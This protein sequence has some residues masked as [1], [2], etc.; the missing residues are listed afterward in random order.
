MK[1]TISRQLGL[2]ALISVIA[3]VIVGIIG[4]RVAHSIGAAVEFSEKKTIPAVEAIAQMRQSFLELR[5]AV[6]GHMTTWDDDEK[7][8]LEKQIS[9]SQQLFAAALAGYEKLAADSD[10][11]DRQM[12]AADRK[13]YEDYVAVLGPVLE[14]SRNSQNTEAKELLVKAKPII[15]KLNES[16]SAHTT[17]S[18][19]LAGE[20]SAAASSA[21]TRGNVLSLTSIALGVLLLGGVSYALTRS[22]SRGL[23]AMVSTIAEVEAKLDLTLRVPV[24]RDDEIG[25]MGGAI[26]RLLAR[27]Q[28]NLQ[29]VAQAAGQLTLAARTMN[30]ASLQVSSSS[31]AQSA[32]AAEMAAN[33]QQLTVSI[34]HVGDRATHTREHVANAGTLATQG[35]DDVVKTVADIDAVART[36]ST[37]AELIN[38]LETQSQKIASVVNVIKEVADQTNLLALNAAIEAARAGEQGRGFA[39]VADEVRKLAERTGHSTHEIT[40]TIATMNSEAQAAAAGMKEAVDQVNA[41]VARANGAC[42]VMRRIGGGSR[43]AVAMVSEITEAILEQS[44]AS[45]AV[46]QSVERIAQMAESSTGVAHQSADNAQRLNVL[47]GKMSEITEQYRL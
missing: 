3:L 2:M 19:K 11:T 17:Y 22:I 12:L 8:A 24:V 32:A 30:D 45:T 40:Q 5:V 39:V 7:K 31:D 14:Q 35:E 36:V 18:K 9:E 47:A 29:S 43:E 33:M 26:N 28:Q 21:A 15:A 16:L 1:L 34:N 46:A 4:N 42:E 44:A 25:R 13:A 41:S 20:Q 23:A 37:A 27:F 10:D 6:H 38:R